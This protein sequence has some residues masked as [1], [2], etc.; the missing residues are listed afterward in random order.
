MTFSYRALFFLAV[1]ASLS[2]APIVIDWEDGLWQ[3]G[4]TT[5]TGWQQPGAAPAAN[6]G[7]YRG[8]T[9]GGQ[10]V[11]EWRRFGT[12]NG[13]H[14]SI[15]NVMPAVNGGTGATVFN[16]ASDDGALGIGTGGDANSNALANYVKLSIWFDMTVDVIPFVIG[17]VDDASA[18]QDFVAVEGSLGGV[19][20]VT[21]Y[22]IGA[23][24]ANHTRLGKAGVL[25]I[26]NFNAENGSEAANVTVGFDGAVDRI[27]VYFLQG[28][29]GAAASAHGIWMRDLEGTGTPEPATSLLI[30]LPLGALLLLSRRLR[31]IS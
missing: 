31:K 22:A 13:V 10:I 15:G 27:D 16:G 23:N 1:C 5:Y 26:N 11:V 30:T 6:T 28:P 25:G 24:Q 12:A 2:A 21:S 4:A 17:D 14:S 3:H 18:W 29:Q 9:A 19:Q 8:S 7:V 20:R